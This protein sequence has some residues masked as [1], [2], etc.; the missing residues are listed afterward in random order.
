V[1]RRIVLFA[2][3]A[4]DL[5]TQRTAAGAGSFFFAQF[6]NHPLARKISRQLATPVSFAALA[7]AIGRC[8]GGIVVGVVGCRRRIA[9][10]RQLFHQLGQL[11]RCEEHQLIGIDPFLPRT[12]LATEQLGNPLLLLPQLLLLLLNRLFIL[13]D[14]LIML[15]DGLLMLRDGLIMLRDGLIMLRD[16]LLVLRDG[17]LVLLPF[18]Q[19]QR[20]QLCGIVWQ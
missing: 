1:L 19:Q 3:F 7:P 11:V 17:L 16:G 20:L 9:L 8:L 5:L 10:R 13:R 6:V 4:A 18:V 12:V 14:G 15:C 2:R